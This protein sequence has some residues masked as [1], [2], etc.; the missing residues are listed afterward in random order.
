MQKSEKTNEPILRKTLKVTDRRTD[1]FIF[2]YKL[3]Y[4]CWHPWGLRCVCKKYA[5]EQ[6]YLKDQISCV[7]QLENESGL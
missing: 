4:H 7:K 2:V 6:S 1:E 5:I 3:G